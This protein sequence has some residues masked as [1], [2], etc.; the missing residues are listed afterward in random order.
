MPKNKFLLLAFLLIGCTMGAQTVL[1]KKL[2]G[3]VYSKDGDVA[4]THVLNISSQRAAITD[5]DGYFS[6]TAKLNDTIVFSAV[7][8]QRKELVV[9]LEM[10]ESRFLSIPLE[11]AINELDEVIV[12]PYNLTGDMRRDADR[13]QTGPVVTASTLNLPNAYVE[14]PNQTE[15]QLMTATDARSVD[16]VFNAI[17][18]RT[19]RLKRLVGVE[20]KYARTERVRAFYADSLIVSDL[21]I[22][23]D[24]IDDFM[25]FCEVDTGFQ[26]AVDSKDQLKIWEMMRK[27]SLLYRK[28]NGLD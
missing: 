28:N 12:M 19:K 9:T 2:E 22:P 1:S 6:I 24:K 8:F 18:G 7:Q 21:R 15:R 13:I 27:R 25:Y 5:I 16:F 14:L 10:L 26:E 11:E 4:A 3:R 17:S 23:R 20:K